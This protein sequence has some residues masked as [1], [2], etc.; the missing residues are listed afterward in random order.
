MI[1]I[2][3]VC[4]IIEVSECFYVYRRTVFVF[5]NIELKK[6]LPFYILLIFCKKKMYLRVTVKKY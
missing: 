1:R 6:N 2:N 5:E 4:W 3:I